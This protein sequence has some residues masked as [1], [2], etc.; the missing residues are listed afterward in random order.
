MIIV[1][2][3]KDSI[4]NQVYGWKSVFQSPAFICNNFD[5]L[6]HAHL[7]GK[8]CMTSG[9]RQSQPLLKWK[10]VLGDI[11]FKIVKIFLLFVNE[12]VKSTN[13][14]SFSHWQELRRLSLW[15]LHIL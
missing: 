3:H 13:L 6:S 10:N 1:I 11:S 14:V 4:V 9:C 8:V 2:R 7:F 15:L 12:R 5:F